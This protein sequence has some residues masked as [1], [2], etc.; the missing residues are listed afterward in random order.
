MVGAVI[1]VVIELLADR[2]D[3]KNRDIKSQKRAGGGKIHIQ[4]KIIQESGN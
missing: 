4:S 2:H 1:M 3:N